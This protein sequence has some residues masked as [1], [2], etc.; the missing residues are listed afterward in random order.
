MRQQ[1]PGEQMGYLGQVQNLA[2]YGNTYPVLRL[3]VCGEHSIWKILDW[4]MRFFLNSNPGHGHLVCVESLATLVVGRTVLIFC[5]WLETSLSTTHVAAGGT[6]IKPG[7]V[8]GM[9][10]VL[11]N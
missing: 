10:R 8:Q 7:L 1:W 9:A 11:V 3:R 4:K 2:A 6:G 5:R